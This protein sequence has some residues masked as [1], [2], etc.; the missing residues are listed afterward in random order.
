MS[1]VP[2]RS[3][4]AM[5][6]L[7]VQDGEGPLR[8]SEKVAMD[9]MRDL[10]S[11]GMQW[12][13]VANQPEFVTACEEA[14]FPAV[15]LPFRRLF[16]GGG[17]LRDLA[18]VVEAFNSLRAIARDFKPDLIHVNNGGSCPWVV[19]LAWRIGVP[20]LVHVH[21]RWSRKMRFLQA[22]HLPDRIVAV[23]EATAERFRGDPVAARKIQVIHNATPLIPLPSPE[24]K[25]A[26]RA[27]MNIPGDFF[28][29]AMVGALI[30]GKSP[31]DAI[32]AMTMLPETVKAKTVLLVIGEGEA[33]AGLEQEAL[34][35]Q[36][37][38][39][40]QRKD[41][42]YL[43]GHVCDA[44]ILPSA[45]EAFSLVLLEAAA[46]G[47]ARIAAAGG[48]NIEAITDGQ[49]GLLYEPGDRQAC[50]RAIAALACDRMRCAEFG[51]TARKRAQT[52]FSPSVFSG[53]FLRS[54]REIRNAPERSGW[55]RLGDGILSMVNLVGGFKLGG[56]SR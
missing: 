1:K 12:H 44:L 27:A 13:V 52:D 20:V 36:V 24:A 15:L 50:A 43:L 54:Y 56:R 45:I 32:A 3:S 53:K 26:A 9:L 18:G 10:R 42:D 4:Q 48:G 25:L 22:L 47:I 2:G 14:G 31:G 16:L 39:L 38:F 46:C 6:I 37:R 23:S 28:V 5:R 30:R 21:A 29:L 35:L 8:G 41:V 11:Q 49:D 34:G 51:A 40:G 17:K 33:Q 55:I 7:L 19:P